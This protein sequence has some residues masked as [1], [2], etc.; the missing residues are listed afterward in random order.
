L[1]YVTSLTSLH[2]VG[3]REAW[4]LQLFGEKQFIADSLI[5]AKQDK[6]SLGAELE[7]PGLAMAHRM[8][9]EVLREPGRDVY[10]LTGGAVITQLFNCFCLPQTTR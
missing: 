1:L 9:Q 3:H 6:Q 5:K 2:P 7:G 4:A 10:Q 8:L